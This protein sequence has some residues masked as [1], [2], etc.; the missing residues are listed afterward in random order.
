MRMPWTLANKIVAFRETSPIPEGI[1]LVLIV[2]P[3]TAGFPEF[4]KAAFCAPTA[5]LSASLLNA[6][7]DLTADGYLI[8]LPGLS[9]LVTLE[10]SGAKFF[11]LT[12]ALMW[13]AGRGPETQGRQ[14]MWSCLKRNTPHLNPLPQGERKPRSNATLP[15]PSG[16]RVGVRVSS[17]RFIC[18]L[19]FFAALAYALTLLANTAR[20]VL[21][22]RTALAARHFLP[23]SFH[24]GVHLATG[25]V[26]FTCF[27][28]AGYALA[29][30]LTARRVSSVP[31]P[32]R[33]CHP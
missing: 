26:V 7:W 24:A 19:S 17:A 25:I 16:E 21:G 30:W 5:F 9:V 1:L 15:L 23:D 10:C 20:I 22:W 11:C 4:W 18:S 33:V 28:V 27:L 31:A 8:G 2:L 32:L 14:T 6:P 29:S 3:F 13:A 12:W